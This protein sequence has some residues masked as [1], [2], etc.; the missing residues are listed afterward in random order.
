[1]YLLE[2]KGTERISASALT[3]GL[4]TGSKHPLAYRSFFVRGQHSASLVQQNGGVAEIVADDRILSVL[5]RHLKA[6]FGDI[7]DGTK[8]EVPLPS[9]S[10]GKLVIDLVVTIRPREGIETLLA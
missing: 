2:Q 10:G 9:Y 8:I 6:K 5:S 4:S 3:T 1:M 7:L